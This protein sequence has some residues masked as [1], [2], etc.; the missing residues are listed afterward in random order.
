MSHVR[1]RVSQRGGGGRDA[2]APP[3]DRQVAMQVE[4]LQAYKQCQFILK[5]RPTETPHISAGEIIGRLGFFNGIKSRFSVNAG[6]F[7]DVVLSLRVASEDI[8]KEPF[9]HLLGLLARLLPLPERTAPRCGPR[10]PVRPAAQLRL[11]RGRS[12]EARH[13]EF[14]PKASKVSSVN[15]SPHLTNRTNH[16]VLSCL[17]QDMLTFLYCEGSWTRGIFR[18]SARA[19]AVRELRDSLDAGDFRLPL[20]RDHVFVIAG[21]FKVRQYECVYFTFKTCSNSAGSLT[22]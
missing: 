2:A 7:W 1:H 22:C 14:A 3:A 8:K 19:R 15:R 5:P 13:G 10:L 4:Q 17:C 16:H 9:S 20:T 18:R 6:A 11:W 12:A 21:V